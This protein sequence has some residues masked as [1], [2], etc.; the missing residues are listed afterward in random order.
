MRTVPPKPI[1]KVEPTPPPK[2]TPTLTKPAPP[3]KPEKSFD[4]DAL[5]ASL[6]TDEKDR[7]FVARFD[8]IRLA[9]SEIH[10][11]VRELNLELA[12]PTLKEAFQVH[13][14]IAVGVTPVEEVVRAIQ[15]RPKAIQEHL[16]AALDVCLAHVPK[17][18]SQA[19]PWLSAVLET[20]DV[21][22]WR[23]SARQ[24][25]AAK[26]WPALEKLVQETPA[27]RQPPTFLSL[28][29]M[30]IPRETPTCLSLARQIQRAHRDDFWANHNLAGVLHYREFPQFNE[31]IRYYTAALALRPR[32][33]GVLVNLGNALN[34]KGDL[35]GAMT[36]YR[37]A[38]AVHPDNP[39]AHER[40][41]LALEK[42]GRL[43]EAIAELRET[44]RLRNY[45]P[46]YVILGALLARRGLCDEASAVFKQAI[47]LDPKRAIAHQ[48]GRAYELGTVYNAWAWLLA[49]A[50]DAKVR[51][52]A[53]AVK[54]AKKA[55]ECGPENANYWNTLGVAQ[56]RTGAWQEAELALQKSMD[57]GQ[58]GNA[59]DWLF[60]G[61]AHW[62][63]G[64]KEEARRQY[65]RAVQWMHK[66]EPQ[67]EELL[68][69]RSEA[70]EL[71]VIKKKEP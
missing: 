50:P 22:P 15:Q 28:L 45:V 18:E 21:D 32:N 49:T 41:G 20:A 55:V 34:G 11:A 52:P 70:E 13:Y 24:A 2:F 67:N 1:P 40:L 38:L 23:K 19:R 25:L 37:D 47:E 57:F 56:Y 33:P 16:L 30:E 59:F 63:L 42:K 60:L 51:N 4:L 39:L 17:E 8:E 6:T 36:A 31:A 29:A 58:G 35:D 66:N 27:A 7:R 44:I 71:L 65:D 68:R 64:Q 62:H 54:L 14:R 61:M 26:D 46:D 69:F 9:Q 43:D 48:W 12:F 10:V 53:E 3:A 5:S